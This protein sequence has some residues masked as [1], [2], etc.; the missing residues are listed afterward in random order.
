MTYITIKAIANYFIEHNSTAVHLEV[1]THLRKSLA[2]EISKTT[3]MI[4]IILRE[5]K[6]QKV[7]SRIPYI[8][9]DC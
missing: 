6:L 5:V 1:E 3:A 7:S 4:L 2:G 8:C 9:L